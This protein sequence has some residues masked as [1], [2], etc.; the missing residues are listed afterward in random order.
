[1]KKIYLNILKVFFLSLFI[2]GYSFPQDY[3]ILESDDDHITLEFNFANH[4]S[5][6][7][8]LIDGIKFSFIKDSEFPLQEP[9]KPLLPA[10]FYNIG[11]PYNSNAKVVILES[12][13]EVIKDKFI[14]STPDSANQPV[15]KLNYDEEVYGVNIFYPVESALINS[16]SIYR[17]IKTASIQISPFQFNPVERTLI[18]NKS[19]KVKIDYQKDLLLKA[20]IISSDDKLTKEFIRTNL[21]NS[22]QAI[23]FTGSIQKSL[24][25][26]QGEYWYNPNKNYYKIYL[27]KEGVYRLTYNFLSL[28]G[29][30]MQNLYLSKIQIFNNG[31][32]IPLYIH[33]T[34]NNNLFDNDDYCEFVGLPPSPS[35]NSYLN[36]YNTKNIYW[37]SYEADS[38]GK[39]YN[40]V[41]GFPTT[42]TNSYSAT[43]FTIHYEE[44]K[45]F[46]R[47]GH[48]PDDKRD[49]WFWGKTSGLNG[50][51]LNAF[52][53][54]FPSPKN[55]SSSA[56]SLKI[57]VNLQGMTTETCLT[58]DHRIKFAL[59]SQPIGEFTFD[60]PNTATFETTVNFSQ[61]GIFPTNN[62]QVNAYGD[63][64]VNPCS[65]SSSKYDEVRVNWFEIE[66]LR[67]HRADANNFFF[68][69]PSDANGITRFGVFNWLRDNMRILIPGKSSVIT[70]PQITNDIYK[71]VL[72]VDNVSEKQ[73]YYCV[74]EDY[75]VLPDSIRKTE[76]S[77]LRSTTNGA[78]LIIISHPNFLSAAE[79]LKN[80]RLTNFPDTLVS[81][82][83]VEIVNINDIYNEFSYGL[84]NPYAIK[85]FVSYAFNNWQTPAPAYVVLLGDMSYD[86]RSLIPGSR[87]DFIPSIP[88][89]ARVYG[90]AASDNSFVAVAGDDFKPDLAIGRLSCETLDEA[91]ILVDKI[92]NY[93]NDNGKKWKQNVM[94]IS[95]GADE[96]DE[97]LL[98]FNESNFVLDRNYL[99]P[100]GIS[101][102]KIFRY[103]NP[104]YPDQ[105][106]YKGEGPE[107]RAGFNEGAVIANYYGH[108]GGY[109]WDLVFNND[110]I[111]QLNNQ[112]RLPFIS[113]VTCYT[114]HFDNQDVFGE[115]FNKVPGKGSIAFFGSSGL[116]F[117]T[118]G[119]Y[120]N[121]IMFGQIFNSKK[122]IIGKAIQSAKNILPEGGYYSDQLSLLTLLGDP[123][124]ELAIPSKPDFNITSDDIKISP[125]T[126]VIND[127]VT[128]NATINNYGVVFPGDTL[129]VQLQI[130]SNDTSFFLP[131]KKLPSFGEISNAS[132]KWIP[133]KGEQYNITLKL[134]E[135]NIIPEMDHSDN[136]A[137]VSVT[138]Y[139]ISSPNIIMPLNGDVISNPTIKFLFADNG[140]YIN[141]ELKYLIEID[142]SITFK[143]PVIKSSDIAPQNGLLNWDSPQLNSGVYFWRTRILSN[144]DSS[145]WSDKFAIRVDQANSLKGYVV[146][147][148][149]LN[150][151][152]T[153][154]VLYSNSNN[155]LFLNTN[156]LPPRPS[157]NKFLED[158]RFSLPP[159]ISNLSAITN[160]G[161]YIYIGQMA[162]YSGPSKIYKLGTGYN[163]TVKGAL[164]GSVPNIIVPIW[165]TMFYYKGFLY[166]ATGKAHSLLKINPTTGDTISVSISSGL[167]NSVD[168]QVHDGAF[169]LATDGRYVYNVAYLTSDGTN[170]YTIRIFDPENNWQLVKDLVPTDRSY[171]NFCGFF[172]A[173]GYFYPYENY[174]E[175]YLR[176]I[177]LETGFYEEEWISFIPF[178]GYY[179][180]TYDNVNDFV[181]ASV[182]SSG[183]SPKISKFA[184]KYRNAFGTITTTSI[185]P[186]SKWNSIDYVMDTNGSAGKYSATLQGLNKITRQWDTLVT[187]LPAQ[188]IPSVNPDIYKFLRLSFSLVD[189]SFGLSEPMQL[190]SVHVDYVPPPEI[191]I[192][193]DNIKFVPDSVL[194][195][196]DVI[197]NSGIQNVTQIPA[198]SVKLDY[199]LRPI[200]FSSNETL[201]KSRILNL[202]A[203]SQLTFT[204]T[205]KTTR[206]LFNNA[207]K[208]VAT[209]PKS[210]MF[211]FNNTYQNSFYVKRDSIRP[212]FNITFDGKEIINDDIISSQ[213]N[214][215]IILEDNSPL[216]LSPSFISITHLFNNVQEVIKIPSESATFEYTPFPNSKAIVTWKPIF[217]DGNHTLI[218]TAKDSSNNYFDSKS[219][220]IN[221]NVYSNPDLRDVYNY[222]NPFADNTYFTF[223]IR[224][225]A[226][227]EEFKIKIFTIAGRLIKE[228]NI[229]QSDLRIGFNKIFWD[230]RD[231]DGDIIANGLY[232]YKIISKQNNEVRTITQKLAKVK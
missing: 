185:G 158:I 15:N 184:G 24:S 32:E 8:T 117:W 61:V 149:Q 167:L 205:L 2:I 210:D 26:I 138:V 179:A 99:I 192:T 144:T 53:A 126:P 5:V 111:Y 62:M 30:P 204:D 188:F 29:V 84:L 100:N 151:F 129:S 186:A 81:N 148:N 20:N 132:F 131:V 66:Y 196:Y 67:D 45:I 14:I 80:Y 25:K 166:V 112:G 232:F 193:K 171:P 134:N 175:G 212:V 60:G 76:N 71:M 83:R 43:P 190:K 88:Y 6:I 130:S 114:A 143:N 50:E 48:A 33:D 195:G 64:P 113:S 104:L 219:Y 40:S 37:F 17:F 123:L 170:K 86:Y 176:R 145:N 229:P 10:R 225:V 55:L 3:K 65:P 173:D 106:Q 135:I 93:P 44:D 108:G 199:Y 181:Y 218:V 216:P 172:I 74:A 203:N 228:F 82:P 96:A 141:R 119:K 115:Q 89:H 98:G 102:N 230:G 68:E 159:D 182:F 155:S 105:F 127:T 168:T 209:Y 47:L 94:L 72:F 124:L 194:Q 36:I 4:F 146:S 91:N 90:Q 214:I 207:V 69:A 169:Y 201:L 118:I 11:L 183:R 226:P 103:P 162:F 59:T 217:A 139:D 41:N 128:I 213:P 224:G 160:D 222:P 161:T 122:R 116:T 19:L 211:N 191:M 142:T 101:S 7:D 56:T 27:A 164:Y 157:N 152:N 220:N 95:S 12:E 49:Y 153:E 177:N 70:N 22:N 16:Q 18:F 42:W 197:V 85:D 165:H 73:K 52:A 125:L 38:A 23:N 198:D 58:P 34:N 178:Q 57:R 92:I 180:W 136:Q 189:S 107:I 137:S 87:P 121:E 78:D 208:L 163:G 200:D 31:I 120:F 206:L 215:Q 35:P 109:Q 154:N 63:I 75:S 223:E 202:G 54:E 147:N 133:K 46:E 77:N 140:Y 231:Q 13:R 174:Q 156:L 28:A 9:G 97:N 187:S 150:L 1:M 21:I 221:F 51:L 227:P 110:D 39:R 79:R